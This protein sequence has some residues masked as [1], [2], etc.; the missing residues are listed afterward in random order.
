MQ[1]RLLSV[2]QVAEILGLQP[3]TIYMWKWRRQNFHFIKLGKVLRI[4]DKDLKKFIA[5]R[6]FSPRIKKK[7]DSNEA[8]QRKRHSR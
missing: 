7:R 6:T 1:E 3:K 8:I 5:L 2:K 4:A